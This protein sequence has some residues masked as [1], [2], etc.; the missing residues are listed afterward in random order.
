MCVAPKP[1]AA[2]VSRSAATCAKPLSALRW[3]SSLGT[4]L[5][6]KSTVS[7]LSS[8]AT[9]SG[10]CG[11]CA[12]PKRFSGASTEVGNQARLRGGASGAAC[13][14]LAPPSE[15]AAFFADDAAEAS[16]LLAS[17]GAILE[18]RAAA[19]RRLLSGLEIFP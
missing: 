1:S 2:M 19:R 5:R 14:A 17:H 13:D 3:K 12:A 6:R 4:L 11:V 7:R 9:I 16:A 10:T 15:A 18:R 8:S